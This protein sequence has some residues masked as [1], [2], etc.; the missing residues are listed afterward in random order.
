VV[1]EDPKRKGLLYAGTETGVFVSFNDGDEWEPLQ[2]NL[3]VCPIHDLAIKQDD[4][5]AA[6]HGRSFWVLDDISC[7]RQ[8]DVI[9]GGEDVILLKPRDSY[10][11]RWGTAVGKTVGKN[12]LGGAVFTY[13]LARDTEKVEFEV[14]DA[15]GDVVATVKEAEGKAGWH[16]VSTDLRYPSY[17][18]VPGMILWAAY[19]RPIGA[20]P[21]VYTVKLTAGD[22]FVTQTFNWLRDPRSEATD[23]DL[24]EQVKFAREISARVTEANEAVLRIRDAKEKIDKAQ[25]SA[26]DLAP[27]AEQLKSKLT[28]V[29]SEIYQ[30]KLK[31]GQ[32]P[33]NYPIKVNN[34]LAALLGTV[35]SGDGRPTA[36]SYEVFRMLSATLSVHLQS[37]QKVL[38]TDLAAF[39]RK[40]RERNLEPVVPEVKKP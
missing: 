21:G 7:L 23:A 39:N 20:P 34:K 29:E 12:P 40:L 38:D 25:E 11:A 32:D 37:L 28:A 2:L 9:A 30:I 10:R 13:Y 24:V 26:M 22:K 18:S 16:Q 36:Q 3:P 4:L 19:S 35:L 33:L 5:I 17:R 15:R 8:L 6:T 27:D 31:S 1:R 14:T